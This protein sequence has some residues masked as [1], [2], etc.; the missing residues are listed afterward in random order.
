MGRAGGAL[1]DAAIKVQASMARVGSSPGG[2][3]YFS[4]CVAV[5]G[6]LRLER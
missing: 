5:G 1:A 6:Q 3:E 4:A 2:R